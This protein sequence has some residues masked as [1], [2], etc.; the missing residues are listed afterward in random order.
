MCDL[1]VAPSTTKA[2]PNR[3]IDFEMF[4]YFI[5]SI[6]SIDVYATADVVDGSRTLAL[7]DDRTGVVE[8]IAVPLD[9]GNVGFLVRSSP[10]R[11]IQRL[12][13]ERFGISFVFDDARHHVDFVHTETMNWEPHVAPQRA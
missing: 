4:E 12:I 2:Y 11:R 1:H 8:L 7:R 9:S 3:P 6:P 10:S 5:R 13:C